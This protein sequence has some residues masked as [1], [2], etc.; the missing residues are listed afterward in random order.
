MS[1]FIS[2]IV[3][4]L[5][6]E[7]RI[8][9]CLDSIVAQ[10][11]DGDELIVVDNGSTDETIQVAN[12]KGAIIL[13]EARR[14]QSFAVARGF[15][16][17]NNVILARTDA[18]SVV[19]DGWL[20][21]IRLSFENNREGGF[22]AITG[23]TYLKEFLPL[24][25][26]VHRGLAKR[27]VGHEVLVGGNSAMTRNLWGS[28]KGK[29][30]NDDI[31]YAEDVEMSIRISRLGGDIRFVDGMVVSTSARWMM[32]RPINSYVVWRRK[33]KETLRLL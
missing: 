26:G 31:S 3:P 2:I 23:P 8:G 19:S 18:D 21:A 32:I 12:S 7:K 27:Y 9:E 17:A 28:L 24:K 15:D 10:M 1:Q 5:N 20:D 4:A 14:G 33:M 22:L 29:M 11:V 6:E 16:F 13:K 30:S 25:L